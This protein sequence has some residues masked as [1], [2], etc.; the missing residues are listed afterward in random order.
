MVNPNVSIPSQD[1]SQDESKPKFDK[2][3]FTIFMSDISSEFKD[4]MHEFYVVG[5]SIKLWFDNIGK[6]FKNLSSRKKQLRSS[7][8]TLSQT[9]KVEKKLKKIEEQL[10]KTM[11]LTKEIKEDTSKKVLDIDLVIQ[12]LDY[13]MERVEDIEGYMKDNLGSDWL[14]IK[15]IW[16]EYKEGEISR[17]DFTKSALKKLGKSFLGIFVNTVS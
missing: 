6:W 2:N 17:G 10:L 9:E 13:Q 8:K 4:G 15:N 5:N 14:K 16:N 1:Q 11:E 7:K 12:I 3:N